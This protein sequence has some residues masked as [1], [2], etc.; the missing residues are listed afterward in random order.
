[1][2]KTDQHLT[3]SLNCCVQVALEF[4]DEKERHEISD[5]SEQHKDFGEFGAKTPQ[6]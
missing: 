1:M 3:V 5:S 6:I 4:P 2:P